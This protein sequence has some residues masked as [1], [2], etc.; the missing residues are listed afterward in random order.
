MK[1]GVMDEQILIQSR[2]ETQDTAGQP[3]ITWSDWNTVWA[4]LIPL[5]NDEIV[6]SDRKTETG[7]YRVRMR[8]I[9]GLTEDMRVVYNSKNYDIESI[10]VLGRNEGYEIFIKLNRQMP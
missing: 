9:T 6:A 2:S 1:A 5:K 8:W 4:D 7:N 3:V 10:N